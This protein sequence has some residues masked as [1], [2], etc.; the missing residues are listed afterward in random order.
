MAD[1]I[2]RRLK[3]DNVAREAIVLAVRMHDT[4]PPETDVQMRQLL[5]VLP[6]GFYPYLEA[7][8]RAD[9]M[10]HSVQSREESLRKLER[11]HALYEGVL[12]RGECVKLAD[13]AVGGRDLMEIG[14][15][16]GKMIG[17][18]LNLLL[19]QVLEKPQ[20]NSKELLLQV[21]TQLK[22]KIGTDPEGGKE[23]Q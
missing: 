15:P 21:A 7:L 4:D 18:V 2:L 8:Q 10:V 19:R 13:L 16:R 6:D 5:S 20:V 9:A 17:T 1:S 12:D 23:S 3:F 14:Y 22:E 11:A